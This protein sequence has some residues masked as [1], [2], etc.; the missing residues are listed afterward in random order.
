MK[1]LA[2]II[3]ALRFSSHMFVRAILVVSIL[4][5]AVPALLIF[6]L[7]FG[8][9]KPLQ[10]TLQHFMQQ[11]AGVSYHI[12]QQNLNFR[13]LDQDGKWWLKVAPSELHKL[14]QAKNMQKAYEDGR[15]MQIRIVNDIFAPSFSI[16][17]FILLKGDATPSED[18]I[19]WV[20]STCSVSVLYK[21]GDENVFVEIQKF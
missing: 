17:D 14:A 9:E 16:Q 19:C 21:A 3:E 11:D 2:L 5:F 6:G 18:T 8:T 1:G 20:N 10:A 15:E 7:L 4:S 12:H 13:T